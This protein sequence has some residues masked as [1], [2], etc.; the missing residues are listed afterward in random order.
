MDRDQGL[1]LENLLPVGPRDAQSLLYVSFGFIEGQ[2]VRLRPQRQTLPQ[3]TQLRL[4]LLLFQLRLPDQ[5]NLKELL[6]KGLEIRKHADLFQH[7]VRKILGLVDDEHRGLSRPVAIEQPVI[8]AQQNLALGSRIARNAEVR[9]HVV[10]ELR[11]AH[12]R[13]ENERRS[14]LL[15]AQPLQQLVDERGFART[16]FPREQDKTFPALDSVGQAGQRLLSMARQKQ[17][18]RVRIDVERVCP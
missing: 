4:V 10:Q 2:C 14:D 18:T 12:A 13:I 6:R 8:E 1:R 7:F 15:Q 9:H 3:L 5:N 16:H 17:I 11:D